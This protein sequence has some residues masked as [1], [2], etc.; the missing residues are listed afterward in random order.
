LMAGLVSNVHC[1]L[2]WLE[3]LRAEVSRMATACD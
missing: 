1:M 2:S 3:T